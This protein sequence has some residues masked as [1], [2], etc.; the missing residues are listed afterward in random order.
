MNLAKLVKPNFFFFA[1][2]VLYKNLYTH[3]LGFGAKIK[4][5]ASGGVVDNSQA[6][7]SEFVLSRLRLPGSH[8]SA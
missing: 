7:V 5:G 1:I 4:A 2:T 3:L 8:Q 6:S